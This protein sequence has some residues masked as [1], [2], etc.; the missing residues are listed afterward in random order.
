MK[1]MMI[2]T[3]MRK[4]SKSLA[5]KETRKGKNLLVSSTVFKVLRI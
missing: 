3:M 4:Q 5:E 2:M 1:I